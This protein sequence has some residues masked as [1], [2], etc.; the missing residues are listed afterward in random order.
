MTKSQRLWLRAARLLSDPGFFDAERERV[1]EEHPLLNP[2]GLGQTRVRRR[3]VS[4][5]NRHSG[6]W[7]AQ[8]TPDDLE[9]AR[10]ELR[11]GGR[12]EGGIRHTLEY[13]ADGRVSL[14]YRLQG[15]GWARRFNGPAPPR[16]S[17][18]GLKHEVES[19]LDELDERRATNDGVARSGRSTSNGAFIC[20]ALMA[21][22]RMWTYKDS[23]NP[24]FRL[25]RPW[26]VAGMQPED[27]SQ[28]DD[29]RMA[30][31]WRWVVQR[32]VSDSQIEDFI[33]ATVE[34]LYD[35]A[36]L[37]QLREAVAQGRPEARETYNRLQREFGFDVPDEAESS[38]LGF[39]AGQIDVPDDFDSMGGPEIEKMFGTTA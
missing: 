30:S 26:A 31:F 14:S 3:F 33:A 36:D 22:L 25:G 5:D 16:R 39:M 12:C 18:Y 23:I 24:D 32:E 20:A 34:L 38:R 11:A 8:R 21:G 28:P 4:L 10:D 6:R 35:G 13:L 15:C 17:S 19:Y 37:K 27:Y 9:A 2:D 7:E 1:L 29:E